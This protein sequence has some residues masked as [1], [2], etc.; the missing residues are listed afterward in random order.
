MARGR[1]KNSR[2]DWLGQREDKYQ[3]YLTDDFFLCLMYFNF[4]EYGNDNIRL[5]VFSTGFRE[6]PR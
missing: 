5:F 1:E 3:M 2:A 6:Y 4:S